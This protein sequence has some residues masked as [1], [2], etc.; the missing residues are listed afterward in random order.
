MQKTTRER[1][2]KLKGR[3]FTPITLPGFGNLRAQ[4]LTEG[5]RAIVEEFSLRDRRRVK[6]LIFA[7]TLV[8]AET[9]DRVYPFDPENADQ[10]ESVLTE[11]KDMDG[12][13]IDCVVS[14]SIVLNRISEDDVKSLL[15]ERGPIC[16]PIQCSD[17]PTGSAPTS[18][19]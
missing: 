13:V 16:S 14:A 17:L 4:N 18:E 7:L 1:L 15:G 12:A 3:R 8:E 2:A 5:E 6:R 10:L 9:P 11:L 19:S